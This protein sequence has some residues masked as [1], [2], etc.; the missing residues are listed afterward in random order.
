[1]VCSQTVAV[2]TGLGTGG[3]SSLLLLST[4]DSCTHPASGGP[5]PVVTSALG[6]SQLL[7]WGHARTHARTA[8][9]VLIQRQIHSL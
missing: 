5:E 7:T 8:D 4:P 9:S 2:A 1:M 3:W 6:G